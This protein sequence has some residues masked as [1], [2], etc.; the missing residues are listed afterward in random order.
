MKYLNNIILSIFKIKLFYKIILLNLIVLFSGILIY[1]K[2]IDSHTKQRIKI[3]DKQVFEIEENSKLIGEL[4]YTN[5]NIRDEI[6]DYEIKGNQS[7]Y[8]ELNIKNMLIL[9][10]TKSHNLDYEKTKNYKIKLK[11]YSKYSESNW[12]DLQIILSNKND[13]KPIITNIEKCISLS[14][15]KIKNSCIYTMTAT[16]ADDIN[17]NNSLL[18]EITKGNESDIFYI[19]KNSGEIKINNLD[20][21]DCKKYYILEIKVSDGINK[22]DPYKL[23]IVNKHRKKDQH[24]SLIPNPSKGYSNINIINKQNS[25]SIIKILDLE[26]NT[27]LNI[28]TTK[29]RIKLNT[30][31]MNGTYFVLI[32]TGNLLSID[33]LYVKH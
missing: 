4:K 13:C 15:N 33:K 9:A 27:I 26:G 7:Y 30:S 19:N 16:D 1:N 2:S 10:K 28:K 12:A 25:K 29:N 17:N 20:N 21:I 31:K 23:I 5:Q 32:K 22:S 8:F 3:L 11:L 18:W 6:I 24:F 14:R